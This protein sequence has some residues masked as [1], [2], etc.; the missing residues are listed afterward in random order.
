[1]SDLCPCVKI[2]FNYNMR[3]L[4]YDIVSLGEAF[5]NSQ[6]VIE[7]CKK[8]CSGFHL[9]VKMLVSLNIIVNKCICN[10]T[11]HFERKKEK[12]ITAKLKDGCTPPYPQWTNSSVYNTKLKDYNF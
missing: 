4:A 10:H 11:L 7:R 9:S 8:K 6:G 2:V 12:E 3:F 5:H 1:M